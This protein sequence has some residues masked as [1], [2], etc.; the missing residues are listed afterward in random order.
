MMFSI[1]ILYEPCEW[2]LLLVVVQGILL[3]GIVN[4]SGLPQSVVQVH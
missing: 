3:R 1:A 2:L 4:C